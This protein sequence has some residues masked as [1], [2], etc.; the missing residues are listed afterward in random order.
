M[1]TG[2]LRNA[3]YAV[4]PEP[5]DASRILHSY[6]SLRIPPHSRPFTSSPAA[7]LPP[8]S[9]KKREDGVRFSSRDLTTNEVSRIFGGKKQLNAPLINRMLRIL[10]ERRVTGR[11]DVELPA[12]VKVA[13]SEDTITT[14][15]NWLRKRYPMDEDAAILKRFEREEIE[16][17]QRLIRR[18]LE[19]GLYKP[20]SGKFDKPIEKEGDVYGKSVLQEVRESNEARAKVEVEKRNRE[21]LEG[22]AKDRKV[23]QRQLQKN[24]DL[25][26]YKDS[27]VIEAQPRADPTQRPFLAWLQQKHI[28]ATARDWDT[29]K[30]TKTRRILPSLAL[31]LLTMALCYAFAQYYTPPARQERLL[32]NTPPAA[33]TILGIIGAN[34]L[35]FAMWKACPPAWRMMNKY[36]ISVPMYPYAASIAGS[37]FSHQ[38]ISHLAG[39]MLILWFIGTRHC[40]DFHRYWSVDD[41]SMCSEFSAMRSIV[42]ASPNEAIK[43]PLNEPAIG[44]KKSQ[45]EEFVDYYNGSGVQHIAFRTTDIITT[46]TNLRK[47]GVEFLSVPASYYDTMRERLSSPPSSS[48]SS[49]S[50]PTTVPVINESI[51]S[52]QKLNILIDFDE[53][54]YLLQIF[55]KHVLDRPTVF[56]EIIQRNNFDG[57]GAGNFKSLF[58]AFEREQAVR[59]NL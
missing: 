52:L 58:E 26:K 55:T 3:L 29:S 4:R 18:G 13:L 53:N 19:L 15:L 8:P 22:E 56:L 32:P 51:E 37:I 44:K 46:V 16:E 49:S 5:I 10:Q 45:I 42:I 1:S 34:V 48:S 28:E 38:R 50:S 54:G 30:L 40:L 31:T 21:W 36:F 35:I 2:S 11:I 23:L 59:G 14:G 12:D 25:Q 9:P 47:R 43:M 27:A 41:K 57:F 17:E 7:F 24:T 20:Q 39:N 33:A 6:L